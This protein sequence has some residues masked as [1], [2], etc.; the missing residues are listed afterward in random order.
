MIF[1]IMH[2]LTKK[3]ILYKFNKKK[4]VRAS[5]NLYMCTAE[6]NNFLKFMSQN[7]IEDSFYGWF[8]CLCLHTWFVESRLKREGKEGQFLN[9]F[10][11]SLPVEDAAAR[12]KFINDG[13][14]LLSSDE[15]Q[16]TC[17][18]FAIHKLLDEN[19]NKSDCHLAN[20]IWLCLYNPD[21]TKTRNLE[22]IVE[23]VRR[24][25][26]HIDQIDT[27]T[28]LKSGY[29]DYLNF[30]NFQIEKKKTLKLWNEINYRIYNCRFK[31][32]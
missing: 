13:R 11:T 16:L 31:V 29:I 23:F 1:S 19:I 4:M 30:E 24:Q 21:S 15:K 8:K 12:S 28:L 25:K 6:L 27:K 2:Y 7:E 18:K 32:L 5:Y 26:L 22:K 17:T 3:P 9:T 10:F 20:A 14:H